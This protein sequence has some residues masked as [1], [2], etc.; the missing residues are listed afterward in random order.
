MLE[1]ND[2]EAAEL[3]DKWH[4]DREHSVPFDL[5]YKHFGHSSVPEIFDSLAND[6]S[7]LAQK[8]LGKLRKMS[9]L[10]LCVCAFIA[11]CCGQL[12][13]S[14]VIPMHRLGEVYG[15][16]ELMDCRLFSSS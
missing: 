15:G 10:S 11:L 6:D 5:I 16:V 2:C 4:E 1:N 3:L 14:I 9:P 12:I 8:T 7:V 13:C